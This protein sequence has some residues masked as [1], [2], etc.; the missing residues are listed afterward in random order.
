MGED[1]DIIKA[2]CSNN[3]ETAEIEIYQEV[4]DAK[5]VD[6]E[7]NSLAIPTDHIGFKERID[8]LIPMINGVA[9]AI[10]NETAAVVRFPIVNGKQ[11]GWNDLLNRKTPGWEEWKQLTG[12]NAK[13]KFNPQ[14]AIKKAGITSNPVA[15]A[16]IALQGA[17][18]V[19]GQAYMTEINAKLESIESGIANIERILERDKEAQIEGNY[20]MLKRYASNLED[21]TADGQKMQAVKNS[22]E[23]IR[24][25]TLQLWSYE[26]SAL[27]DFRG[28]LEKPGRIDE[29]AAR[30]NLNELHS[31]EMAFETVY[32]LAML[33]EQTSMQYDNDFSEV[34]LDKAK[35]EASN[36][37]EE[38]QV[39]HMAAVD[40]FIEKVKNMKGLPPLAIAEKREIEDSENPLDGML[41]T[42][43][44]LADR[45]TPLAM[46][47][48]GKKRN[49]AKKEELKRDITDDSGVQNAASDQTEQIEQLRF[50]FN[51]ATGMIITDGVI[52]FIK[53]DDTEN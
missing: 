6:F 29:K 34:R 31:L 20:R 21:N 37:L 53:E 13:G 33:V 15:I 43:G 19:V 47:G 27:K 51:E 40:S 39:I 9:S 11:L 8:A 38:Y 5:P 4:L 2:E 25:E 23:T 52:Q 50:M 18:M 17:A 26:I 46:L 10:P 30:K 35:Q 49:A 3:E 36:M 1:K 22:L 41:K 32:R 14:A 44:E 7:Q 24:K 16:N 45:I 28:K 42:V 48:E 12:F